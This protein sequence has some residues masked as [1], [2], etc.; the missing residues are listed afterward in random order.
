MKIIKSSVLMHQVFEDGLDPDSL[1][2]KLKEETVPEKKTVVKTPKPRKV[3][4]KSIF[5]FLALIVK[6]GFFYNCVLY[7]I[8]KL[9]NCYRKLL[10]KPPS[11]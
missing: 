2:D 6:N 8:C 11:V 1:F 9:R 4:S 5:H 3:S 7:Y 10:Q